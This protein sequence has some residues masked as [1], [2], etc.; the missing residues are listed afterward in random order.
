MVI[1]TDGGTISRAV[2]ARYLRSYDNHQFWVIRG[3]FSQSAL[4]VTPHAT[5]LAQAIAPE[6][7][8]S[9]QQQGKTTPEVRDLKPVCKTLPDKQQPTMA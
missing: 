2:D 4:P 5:S 3:V 6:K 8:L 1:G 7:T 9:H